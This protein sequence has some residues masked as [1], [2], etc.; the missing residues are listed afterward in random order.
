M[1]LLSIV[2]TGLLVMAIG[3]APGPGSQRTYEGAGAGAIIGGVAGGLLKGWKGAVIGGALGAV[4]GAT[5]TEISAQAAREAAVNN[6]PVEYR[7]DD[8]R[9]LVQTEPRGFDERT[10]CDKV[11]EKIWE[12]GRL[13]RD[14]IKEVCRSTKEERRY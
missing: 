4:A 14:E 8:G 6:R 5:I 10:K 11:H 7:S 13:V 1:K 9:D 3:C 12:D 2:L